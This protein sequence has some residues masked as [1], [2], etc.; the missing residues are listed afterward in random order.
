MFDEVWHRAV[1]ADP[2]NR[3][4][5]RQANTAAVRSYTAAVWAAVTCRYGE[6]RSTTFIE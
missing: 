2:G 5:I 1:G 6:H 3:L 4:A